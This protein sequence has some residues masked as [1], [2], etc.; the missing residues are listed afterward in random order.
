MRDEVSAGLRR[1]EAQVGEESA[2]RLRS[3]QLSAGHVATA[4][5]LM[6]LGDNVIGGAIARPARFQPGS[7]NPSYVGQYQS[8]TPKSMMQTRQ[9]GFPGLHDGADIAVEQ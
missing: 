3:S 2:H 1:I 5:V 8:N 9:S 7:S 6:Q 4:T